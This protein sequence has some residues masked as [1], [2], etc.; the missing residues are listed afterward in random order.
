MKSYEAASEDDFNRKMRQVFE[1]AD[2]S[3]ENRDDQKDRWRRRRQRRTA[4]QEA[5]KKRKKGAVAFLATVAIASL[6]ANG[7]NNAGA[8]EP[9]S[10]KDES[11]KRKYTVESTVGAETS[12]EVGIDNPFSYDEELWEGI[13]KYSAKY[14]LPVEFATAIVQQESDGDVFCVSEDGFNSFGATQP[15]LN[16]HFSKFAPAL[17]QAGLL[18]ELIDKSASEVVDDD[19]LEMLERF[20]K[21]SEDQEKY[22]EIVSVLCDIDVNLDV[23][24]DYLNEMFE[25]VKKDF[26]D[27]SEQEQLELTAMSYNGGPSAAINYMNGKETDASKNYMKYKNG[28]TEN[29]NKIKLKRNQ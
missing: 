22:K 6:I 8:T 24:F 11:K 4:K 7:V 1:G 5:L 14:D 10:N 27:L 3:Q 2:N 13:E 29:L 17:E 16:F 21:L 23:G 12:N 18:D 28:V 20:H 9:E 26:P 25:K 15:S 19:N